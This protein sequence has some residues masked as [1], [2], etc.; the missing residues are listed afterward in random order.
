MSGTVPSRTMP[1]P[2]RRWW[3]LAALMMA[4]LVGAWVAG[5]GWFIHVADRPVPPP[6]VSDG[7]VALTGGAARVET[8]LRLLAEDR[9]QRLLI[10]GIGG[11]TDL[12]ALA[13]RAGLEPAPFASRVT[14]GRNAASTRGN[15]AET[16]AWVQAHGV[17]SLI[18]VT[19]YYHMPRALAELR[20][21]MPEVT[22]YAYPVLVSAGP[23]RPRT[24]SLR[25]LVEE[26]TKYLAAVT[27]LST[28][29]PARDLPRAGQ[30]TT[31]QPIG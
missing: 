26:Y 30:A 9:G 31:G 2:R 29:L 18:V 5:L 14:L 28:W 22:L 11:G 12:A 17:R 1:A 8:A 13:H 6:P 21:A 27:G 16:R 19:A 10:S 15:A 3:R 20:R 25:T 7:I 4:G 23:D 24:V